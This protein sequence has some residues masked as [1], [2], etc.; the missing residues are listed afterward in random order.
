[1]NKVI[2]YFNKTSYFKSFLKDFENNDDIQITNVNNN[3]SLLLM[4]SLY[5]KLNKNILIVAPNLYQSQK[6]FDSLSNIMEEFELSFF[7]QDEFITTEMLA[8]SEEFKLERINTV[9]NIMERNTNIVITHPTGL[10]KPLLPKKQWKKAI[11]S[12]KVGDIVNLEKL[13][14]T[15]I[16]YGYKRESTVEKHGDFN[17]KGSILDIYPL[18]EEKAVRIDFFD[19]EIDS[20]IGRAHV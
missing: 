3:I 15:L 4:L 7:P 9:K 2:N 17:V 5:R 18:N 14:K 13:G 10:L 11:L 19:D 16:S 20:K 8:M 1:M 12:Y 6:V